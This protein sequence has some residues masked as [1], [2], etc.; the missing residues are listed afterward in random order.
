MTTEGRSPRT[1][2]LAEGGG[3][4]RV[5]LV[6]VE[7]P[8]PELSERLRRKGHRVRVWSGGPEQPPVQGAQ[9]DVA[10]SPADAASGADIVLVSLGAAGHLGDVLHGPAGIVGARPLGALVVDHGQTSPADTQVAAARVA[11]GG[12]TWVDAPLT[13]AGR[14]RVAVGGPPDILLRLQPYLEAVGLRGV[15]VGPTGTGQLVR[16]IESLIAGITL[17]AACEGLRVGLGGGLDLERSLRVLTAGSGDATMLRAVAAWVH[18]GAPSP[19]FSAWP[20]ALEAALA[21]ARAQGAAVPAGALA[22]GL[23][24]G[25]A[26]RGTTVLETVIPHA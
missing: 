21:A 17:Q 24:T 2:N 15:A 13:D 12:A 9:G 10:V 19:D 23:F 14:P 26:R 5:G 18:A 3:A 4:L 22:H 16:L 11:E 25:L 1:A 6:G 20:P 8:G 7:D